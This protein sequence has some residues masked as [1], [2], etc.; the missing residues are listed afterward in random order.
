MMPSTVAR[1]LAACVL[2]TAPACKRSASAPTGPSSAR[3]DSAPHADP[4]MPETP[5]DAAPPGA[6][7][8]PRWACRITGPGHFGPR[9]V[10]SV[11]A[12]R[13]GAEPGTIA[14]TIALRAGGRLSREAVSQNGRVLLA[15]GRVSRTDAADAASGALEYD[16]RPGAVEMLFEDARGVGVA[17]LLPDGRLVATR[18][19]G[20]GDEVLVE[21]VSD[22]SRPCEGPVN[23]PLRL[24]PL[25]PEPWE[26]PPIS[27]MP[28]SV[29]VARWTLSRDGRGLCVSR[30][31]G[32]GPW[33]RVFV[34]ATAQGMRG[35]LSLAESINPVECAPRR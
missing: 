21:R 28:P 26:F 24:V 19:G 1:A 6:R 17:W 7:F 9:P 25:A 27:G 20:S 35:E 23:D 15:R 34:E 16:V 13:P 2:F 31:E 18:I 10:V 5:S 22:P 12:P 8:E 30:L 11:P 33:G 4:S 14:D 32:E 3:A 29:A